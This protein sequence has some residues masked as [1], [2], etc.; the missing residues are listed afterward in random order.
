M[1]ALPHSPYTARHEAVCLLGQGV[2]EAGGIKDPASMK[3]TVAGKK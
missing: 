2:S 3:L 1:S